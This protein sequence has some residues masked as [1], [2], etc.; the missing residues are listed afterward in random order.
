MGSVLV[1]ELLL[2]ESTELRRLLEIEVTDIV[3]LFLI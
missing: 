3:F 2:V 1:L